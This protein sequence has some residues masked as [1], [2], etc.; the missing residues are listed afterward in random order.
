MLKLGAQ[1]HDKFEINQKIARNDLTQRC[2]NPL[3]EHSELRSNAAAAF[4]E[5]WVVWRRHKQ[6]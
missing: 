2:R 5:R 3:A 4:I 1:S 6:K